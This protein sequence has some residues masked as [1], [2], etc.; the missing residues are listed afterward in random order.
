MS[1]KE[2]VIL[3]MIFFLL[4]YSVLSFLKNWKKNY[5]DI[6]H[7]TQYTELSASTSRASESLL[8]RVVSDEMSAGLISEEPLS[9]TESRMSRIVRVNK[10]K[11]D[12][13]SKLFS[14]FEAS[15][16]LYI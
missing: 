12:Y 5:R 3:C 9:R 14:S 6:S 10:T 13:L 11:R 16:V 1:F 15:P 4:I 8:Q 7:F 2:I